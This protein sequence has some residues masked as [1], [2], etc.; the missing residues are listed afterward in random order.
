MLIFAFLLAT[1]D[2]ATSYTNSTSGSLTK[3]TPTPG[4]ITSSA[5]LSTSSCSA[6][7]LGALVGCDQGLQAG[8]TPAS[9]LLNPMS[10]PCTGA[11]ANGNFVNCNRS[12]LPVYTFESGFQDPYFAG[13]KI[14]TAIPDSLIMVCSSQWNTSVENWYRTAPITP[15]SVIPMTTVYAS[16][17]FR[18]STW[19]T[20]ETIEAIVTISTTIKGVPT[21]TTTSALTTYTDAGPFTWSAFSQYQYVSQFTYTA[22]KPCCFNCTLYGGNVQVYYW[23]TAAPSG[24]ANSTAPP[25]RAANTTT[26]HTAVSTLVN[27]AGF[28]L[29]VFSA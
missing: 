8:Y 24:I 6:P 15:L 13:D 2:A 9:A 26:P 23:P 3:T 21:F 11:D 20:I 1:A 19:S 25:F 27:A 14:N 29:Y 7:G 22:D 10:R 12:G 18:Q 4:T 17:V 16:Q 28:T 5:S